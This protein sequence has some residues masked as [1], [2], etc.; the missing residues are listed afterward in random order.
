MR[1]R[2]LLSS[3]FC[4]FLPL[5]CIRA[6]A[7]DCYAQLGQYLGQGL[8]NTRDLAIQSQDLT[9]YDKEEHGPRQVEP[10]A[11]LLPLQLTGNQ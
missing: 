1:Q 4:P 7:P 10:M 2:R 5:C 11:N 3:E 8:E 6:V 9:Q